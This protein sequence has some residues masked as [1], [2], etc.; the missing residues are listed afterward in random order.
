MNASSEFKYIGV[1]V[2]AQVAVTITARAVVVVISSNL[3]W[4]TLSL[5]RWIKT[6]VMH[7]KT[8]LI[9]EGTEGRL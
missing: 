1:I 3:L 5:R 7:V 2:Y 9:A 4:I 6:C 8:V